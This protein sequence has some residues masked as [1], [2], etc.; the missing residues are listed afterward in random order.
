MLLGILTGV[1]ITSDHLGTISNER[2]ALLERAATLRLRDVRPG[3]WV[4]DTWCQIFTGKL[5]GKKAA[6]IFNDSLETRRYDLAE[7]GFE[8]GAMELLHPM[9]FVTGELILAPHDGALI[10]AG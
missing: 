4:K 3:K 10:V 1:C 2:M 6:A 5:D 7:L 8:N 9:G